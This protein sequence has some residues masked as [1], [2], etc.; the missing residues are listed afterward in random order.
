MMT[1]PLPEAC[2]LPIKT[3]VARQLPTSLHTHTHT[4][5]HTYAH[6]YTLTHTL[7]HTHTIAYTHIHT[8]T[9]TL[10]YQGF[11]Q[12]VGIELNLGY[13]LH[14]LFDVNLNN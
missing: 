4:H 10:I 7:T 6:T 8:I 1:Y 9:H 11:R 14:P 13:Q 2:K 5:T 12:S 3:L